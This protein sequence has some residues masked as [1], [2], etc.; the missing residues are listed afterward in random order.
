MRIV[1]DLKPN[2]SAEILLNNLYKHTQLETTFGVI[3]LAIVDGEPRILSLKEMIE[4]YLRHRK[5][6]VRRRIEHEL[7]LSL[8]HI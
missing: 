2:T 8:I 5:E 6:V 1:L 7:R 4:C 3:N